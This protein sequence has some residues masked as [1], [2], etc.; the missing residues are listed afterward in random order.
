MT[1]VRLTMHVVAAPHGIAY[2]RLINIFQVSSK[3]VYRF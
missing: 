1:R 3:F 2:P